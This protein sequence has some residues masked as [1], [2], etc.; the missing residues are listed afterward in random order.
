[1][2][3][4]AAVFV[5]PLLFESSSLSALSGTNYKEQNESISNR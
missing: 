3:V 1:M 5:M 4:S 2:T